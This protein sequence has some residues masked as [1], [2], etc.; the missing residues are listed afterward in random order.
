MLHIPHACGDERE[1][2][3]HETDGNDLAGVAFFRETNFQYRA[4][5][6][7][8]DIINPVFLDVI[9]HNFTTK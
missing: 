8:W 7:K 9:V 5:H 3:E 4:G 1:G 6:L 2:A